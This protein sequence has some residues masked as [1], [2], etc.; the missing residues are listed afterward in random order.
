ME[1]YPI[2][3]PKIRIRKIAKI[4]LAVRFVDFQSIGKNDTALTGFP[5][6]VLS[7]AD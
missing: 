4:F 2:S 6:W 3:E 1:G 5:A 7:G